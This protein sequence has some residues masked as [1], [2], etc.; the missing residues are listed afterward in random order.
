MIWQK[1]KCCDNK[2]FQCTFK[3]VFHS[4][5][6]IKT[7]I[8]DLS[9]YTCEFKPKFLMCVLKKSTYICQ[10]KYILCLMT[11]IPRKVV[12]ILSLVPCSS[13]AVSK[14]KQHIQHIFIR[15]APLTWN[16]LTSNKTRHTMPLTSYGPC[17]TNRFGFFCCS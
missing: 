12:L 10:L 2:L 13:V 16:T 1:K 15:P 11:V 6:Q 4:A 14:K 9:A 7:H 5:V 3:N 8:Q 17:I